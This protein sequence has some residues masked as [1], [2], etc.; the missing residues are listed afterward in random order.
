MKNLIRYNNGLTLSC[1]L[2]WLK[3][4]SSKT[5]YHPNPMDKIPLDKGFYMEGNKAVSVTNSFGTTVDDFEFFLK[6]LIINDKR[7]SP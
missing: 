4:M 6:I 1:N 7:K 2:T 5:H 3:K